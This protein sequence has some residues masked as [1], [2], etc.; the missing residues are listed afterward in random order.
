M[1]E[2]EL[3]RERVAHVWRGA[4]SY[5]LR[6]P[7]S[8]STDHPEYELGDLAN[9]PNEAYDGVRAVLELAGLDSASVGTA[10][11]NPLGAF[12]RPGNV[13]LV[14]PNLVKELHPR[15]PDGWRYVL[16]HG[17]IIRAV[18]DYVW[19]ALDG[20]GQIVIADAPQTDSSFAKIVEVLGLDEIQRFYAERGLEL[21]VVDLRREEWTNK[22]GVIVGRRQ[23]D[24]DPLGNV[25]FDLGTA[26]EFR[27]HRGEGRFYGADYDVQV[28]NEHHVGDRQE[29]LLARS[30]IECDV[31][32]SL[33]KMKTHKK[34]GITAAMKNLIG[35]NGDKNWLPHHTEGAP[36]AGGDEHPRPGLLHRI[37]R[38]GAAGLR[39]LSLAHPRVGTIFH[40]SARRAGA[41]VFGDTETV[42]RSGNW[43]GNDTLWRTCLDLNKIVLFGNG[44]GSMRSPTASSRKPHLVLLDGILAGEGSGPMNPDCRDAGVLLFAEHP[45]TADAAAAV[46]MGFD[47]DRIPILANAAHARGYPIAEWSWRDVVIRSN[48]AGWDGTLPDIDPADSLHFR[49]HFGWT[50]HIERGTAG[51]GDT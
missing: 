36:D 17:S 22:G 24:G 28:L 41:T 14:K 29:Y 2:D 21:R 5:P 26:S 27:G 1:S 50:G 10:A 12:V 33:P 15:D 6:A 45:L 16:T 42:I 8:P 30:A 43:W 47:P 18:C 44:D 4:R 25:A 3:R 46:L 19:K 32:V 51:H 40:R 38:W 20:S 39:R 48:V 49:P 23:L 37:E 11:W 35:V 7:F 31:F 13:V 34:A 9:E